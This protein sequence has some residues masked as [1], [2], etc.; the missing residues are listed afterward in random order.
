MQWS[1]CF[2]Q[3]L[4]DEEME[5]TRA[6]FHRKP[7]P[8]S[9]MGSATDLHSGGHGFES[10][11]RTDFF[12]KNQYFLHT[13]FFNSALIPLLLGIPS[14]HWNRTW[15]GNSNMLRLPLV[16]DV[17]DHVLC[18]M[19]CKIWKSPAAAF[20]CSLQH[21]EGT[22][23]ERRQWTAVVYSCQYHIDYQWLI[24]SAVGSIPA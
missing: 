3:P 5:K 4:E 1:A 18:F 9:L 8:Y 24:T 20:V 17:L 23:V 16:G 11:W 13:N 2:L 19:S 6:T 12:F 15:S 14:T 10:S 21:V 7:Q 22:G